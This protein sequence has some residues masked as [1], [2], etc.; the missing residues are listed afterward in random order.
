MGVS[1]SG[2]STVGAAVAAAFRAEFLEGDG[3]HPVAN[4]EKMAAG[5]PLTDADREPWL[6]RLAA[7]LADRHARGVPTVLACSAL[8]RAYRDRL[9]SAV[10]RDEVFTVL[11]AADAATLRPRVTE[12]RGH[13]M[14]ASLLES[15]LATLEPLE[16]DEAGATIDASATV[17]DVVAA[18][19][20][21]LRAW[22]GTL[23]AGR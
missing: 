1:G 23:P 11:L 7:L 15:Q 20:A 22:H 3:Y 12:R 16:A 19:L 18:T 21:A 6:T 8:R 2:K 9:A 14:P 4:V 5:I 10:P 13:F 17:G